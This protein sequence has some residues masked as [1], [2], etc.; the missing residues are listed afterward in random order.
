MAVSAQRIIT[1]VYA[2]DVV[3]SE[4]IQ[5]TANSTSPGSI[6]VH[7]L[8]TNTNTVLIPTGTTFSVKA[9][10]IVPPSAN[11]QTITL[12]G[13]T[14]DVGMAI[15]PSQPTSFA[16]GTTVPAEIILNAGGVVDGLRIFWT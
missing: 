16:F 6:T 5:A 15:S 13:T 12:K 11:T 9:M 2:G 7:S 8:T 4:S 14:A 10:T 1:I 3:G